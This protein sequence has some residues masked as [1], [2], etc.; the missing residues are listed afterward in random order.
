MRSRDA[1]AFVATWHRHHPPPAEPGKPPATPY[2]RIDLTATPAQATVHHPRAHEVLDRYG[3]LPQTGRRSYVLPAHTSECDTVAI[4]VMTKRSLYAIGAGALI[5]LGIP[6][7]APAPSAPPAP[8]KAR[9][10]PPRTR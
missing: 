7:P 8:A 2:V 3:W 5:D 10:A 1:K 9:A 6:S 4:T